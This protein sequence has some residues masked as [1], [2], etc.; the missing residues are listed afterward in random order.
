MQ[1]AGAPY[2]LSGTR[3]RTA[4]PCAEMARSARELPAVQVSIT[5][6]RP[7]MTRTISG[8]AHPPASRSGADR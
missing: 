5:S 4:V 3:K 6:P 8:S 2:R 1:R 7:P